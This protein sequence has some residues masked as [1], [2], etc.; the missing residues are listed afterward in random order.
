MR[1]MAVC[2]TLSVSLVLLST[3]SF[4]L[5]KPGSANQTGGTAEEQARIEKCKAKYEAAKAAKKAESV[6][7]Y[8]KYRR[9]YCAGQA[10]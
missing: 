5:I 2:M 9:S 8:E 10:L 3:P 1:A 4:A 7:G 6:W